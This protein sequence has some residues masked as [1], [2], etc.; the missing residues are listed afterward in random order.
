LAESRIGCSAGDVWA[1]AATVKTAHATDIISEICF[2]GAA[3]SRAADLAT[4]GGVAAAAGRAYFSRII[5]IG[6]L[7]SAPVPPDWRVIE[8]APCNSSRRRSRRHGPRTPRHRDS[9]SAHIAGDLADHGALERPVKGRAGYAGEAVE[10]AIG[11][12]S[13]YPPTRSSS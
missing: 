7:L 13:D 12:V 2:I 4:A 9:T 10:Q 5:V 8:P 11:G 1:C 6:Q 3:S